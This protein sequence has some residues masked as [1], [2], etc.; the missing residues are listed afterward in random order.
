MVYEILS[1]WY[2]SEVLLGNAF[3]DMVVNKEQITDYYSKLDL[4]YMK[5]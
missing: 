4:T 3:Q 1:N 2:K 5:Y